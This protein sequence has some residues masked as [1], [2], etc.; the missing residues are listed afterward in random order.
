MF[1]ALLKQVGAKPA[2]AWYKIG[3]I[4]LMVFLK[5]LLQV[6]RDDVAHHIVDPLVGG[7]G[8][9]NGNELA[10][11]A[12]NDR[13]TNLDV[14]IRRAAING[15]LQDAVKGV[16]DSPNRTIRRAGNRP[17]NSIVLAIGGKDS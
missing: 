16:H 6:A 4:H 12:E 17:A 7:S 8:R 10:V 9:L 2:D 3:E 5:P 13:R 1:S 14:N 11:N 15:G